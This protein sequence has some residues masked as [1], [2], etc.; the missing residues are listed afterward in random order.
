[1]NDVKMMWPMNNVKMM[2]PLGLPSFHHSRNAASIHMPGIRGKDFQVKARGCQNLL[3]LKMKF[4]DHASGRT[5]PVM[6]QTSTR[7]E[8]LNF[9]WKSDV[10]LQWMRRI[11]FL[12]ED[13]S[14]SYKKYKTQLNTVNI[15]QFNNFIQNFFSCPPGATLPRGLAIHL[16]FPSLFGYIYTVRLGVKNVRGPGALYVVEFVC[17]CIYVCVN[18]KG[19]RREQGLGKI[20]LIP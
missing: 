15:L 12:Q 7:G 9:L 6:P 18:G 14:G 19:G 17:V 10:C 3:D 4:A 20:N 5:R 16:I 1:M 2:W 11:S 8:Q 13:I